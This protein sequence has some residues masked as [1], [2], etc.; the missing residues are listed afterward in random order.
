[1]SVL[2][3]KD[4]TTGEWVTVGGVYVSDSSDDSI[5]SYVHTEAERL[6]K[7]VQSRQNPNTITFI[8]CSDIH[9][10]SPNN[11]NPHA[12]ANYLKESAES[13]GQAMKLIRE[14]VHIDFAAFLGDAIW[15][16][17]ETAEEALSAVRFVNGCLH[18]GFTGIPAFRLRGNHDNGYNSG[19][20]FT[21]DRVFANIGIFN[22]DVVL[23][24]ENRVGG[25]FYR[26]FDDLKVRV[27]C[28]N[29]AET[30]SGGCLFSTAQIAW[31]S[32]ALNLTEKGEDWQSIILSHHPLDWG[33]DGGGNPIPVINSASGVIGAF[34]GH[35]HNLKV[36][37]MNGT[38]IT[39]LCIPNACYSRENQY[40]TEY[41][42][43]WGE[44]TSYPKTP[45]TA[46]NTSFCVVTIDLAEKKI[47][48]DHYGA[49]YDREVAYDI[50][51]D[52]GYTNLVPTSQADDST[53]PYNGTGY[54]NGVYL[55]SSGG[56]SGDTACVA[57]GYIPYTWA[58]ANPIYVK[59]A[60]VSSESH[61]RI[62]G[63]AT[64]GAA[65]LNSACCSG[66]NLSTYF[67]VENLGDDY[68]KL[69]PVSDNA[70]TLVKYLRLSL[71][72]TG[73]NLIVTINE[74]IE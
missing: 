36:D 65:P 64:K 20:D 74:P 8:A 3:Y 44:E 63:Y 6:A 11:A 33:R 24:S 39:R 59:G 51:S 15:D 56:D 61:V 45:G 25:Y 30:S 28:L 22:K 27:I 37:T 46:E 2:K 62:Y 21:D 53:S 9:Y 67:K 68:Y 5:P 16:G 41:G 73:E 42:V 71:I 69:T 57:T 54:K 70:S 35:I 58:V 14:A 31:L 60:K 55:S 72:G 52:V 29:S 23:D 43:D 1:M 13:L 26:D 34:H 12:Y 32:D 17:G 47:Y 66:T 40:G 7:V 4:P 49:G 48:A 50:G 19:I 38:E 18:D 10:T